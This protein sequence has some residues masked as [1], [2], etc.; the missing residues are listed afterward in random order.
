MHS[1]NID[2]KIKIISVIDRLEKQSRLERLE[3][4]KIEKNDLMLA[5]TED[6]GKFLN[7]LLTSMN[8]NTVLEIG[9]LTL[10]ILHC[11]LPLHSFKWKIIKRKK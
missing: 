9:T 7:I 1:N 4:V 11:G 2:K 6:T 3:K 8:A 5:I 10:D